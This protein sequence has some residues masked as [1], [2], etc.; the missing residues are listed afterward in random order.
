MKQIFTL[1]TILI[2]CSCGEQSAQTKTT[3][4]HAPDDSSNTLDN[5]ETSENKS[6]FDWQQHQDSLRNEILKIKENE[7]LKNSFLQ[8]IYIRNVVTISNDSLHFNIP[9]NLHG[10]DCGAPDCYS[11]DI[12]F[13]FKIGDTLI[14]PKHLPFKEHEHGCIDKPKHLSGEFILIEETDKYII[15]HSIKPKRTLVL[16]SSSKETGTTAFY[17]T[18]VGQYDI[19]GKNIYTIPDITKA[20]VNEKNYPFTS[21]ILTTNDYES[22]IH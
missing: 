1:L 13:T 12:S 9:F 20:N 22:F 3:L 17:F 21:W 7:I 5:S 18:D 19:N 2:L 16:F 15:Y 10:P 6:V 8:E 4:V 11:T 14:F